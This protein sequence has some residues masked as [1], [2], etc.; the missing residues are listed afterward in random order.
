MGIRIVSSVLGIPLL[1]FLI[2][3]GGIFL[4]VALLLVSLI[5]MYEF[6]MAVSKKLNI[7]HI[8]GFIVEIVYI[9]MMDNLSIEN[10]RVIGIITVLALLIMIVAL[11]GRINI[12]DISVSLFGF[13][14][15]GF[16]LSHIILIRNIPTIGLTLV[17]LPFICAWGCDTGAYFV[18]VSIGKHKLAPVLSP[19]KSVEGALGGVVTATLLSGIYG[20][21]AYGL[22]YTEVNMTVACAMFGAVGSVFSQFGDLTASSIKR[23]TKIKD[24]GKLIPGH[25]GVLDRFDSVLFTM[26]VIYILVS[27]LN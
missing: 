19:H 13:F 26:P 21:C 5:G 25:G 14:Y 6:Y 23:Y 11:Y 27:V 24:Y 15:V 17:W 1:I 7:A 4:K 22:G 10:F 8:I 16:L 9:I 20:Y 3:K 12:I 2:V 18:G